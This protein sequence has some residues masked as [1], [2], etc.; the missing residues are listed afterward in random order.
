MAI[1]VELSRCIACVAADALV[2]L[3]V[4]RSYSR[5]SPI[6]PAMAHGSAAMSSQRQLSIGASILTEGDLDE[7]DM[8]L[9]AWSKT[10]PKAGADEGSIASCLTPSAAAATPTTPTAMMDNND[11]DADLVVGEFRFVAGPNINQLPQANGKRAASLLRLGSNKQA[12]PSGAGGGHE[13]SGG[14]EEANATA[15]APVPALLD[16]LSPLAGRRAR[17]L[18]AAAGESL[19]SALASR[20]QW[21]ELE[22]RKLSAQLSQF[23]GSVEHA[24]VVDEVALRAALSDD[25]DLSPVGGEDG[26]ER[27]LQGTTKGVERSSSRAEIRQRRHSTED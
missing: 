27:L 23:L 4:T 13:D 1:E 10:S 15:A 3:P 19:L 2:P 22:N 26:G 8:S 17:Q 20:L 12:P 7:D 21:L 18:S 24:P 11:D 5:R 14:G 25:F 9:S 16:L 6:S